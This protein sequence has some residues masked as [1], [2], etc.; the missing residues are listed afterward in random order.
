MIL[1]FT[2]F[3]KI[4]NVIF[5]QFY[6]EEN[7]FSELQLAL[8]KESRSNLLDIDNGNI[9]EF[10]FNTD[11]GGYRSRIF[12]INNLWFN[13]IKFNDFRFMVVLPT[14]NSLN[15]KDH[16]IEKDFVTLI[17]KVTELIILCSSNEPHF[18]LNQNMYFMKKIEN[19]LS[20]FSNYLINS[21]SKLT[22]EFNRKSNFNIKSYFKN[23][24]GKYLIMGSGSAG[25]SSIINQF[26]SN[27]DQ[28]AIEKIKPTIN[29]EIHNFK[30]NY[31][32]H[33][34]NLI[35]LGGQVQYTKFH[36]MDSSLFSEIHTLIFVIDIQ[37]NTNSEFIKDYLIEIIN[38]LKNQD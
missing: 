19:L 3:N 26:I 35:D 4:G 5:Q 27:W 8:I 14:L 33:N 25:K 23:S 7:Y 20:N 28:E 2:I 16:A 37:N 17:E 34:F 29:K 24:F 38:K 22:T 13:F 18:E 10:A 30:D 31:I 1:V 12:N 21:L 6:S 36:L 32:S 15:N 11:K 9:A